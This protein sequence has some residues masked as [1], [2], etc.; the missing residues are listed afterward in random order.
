MNYWDYYNDTYNGMSEDDRLSNG[1]WNG[2]MSCVCVAAAFVLLLVLCALTSC[3]TTKHITVPGMH[4]DTL[5]ISKMQRD[6]IWLHDSIHVTERQQGDTF[7]VEV[8]KWKTKYIE[9]LHTDT[10]IEHHTDSIPYPVEVVKEVPRALTWWQKTRMR[11]GEILIAIFSIAFIIVI[12]KI[13]SKFR[14]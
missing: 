2:C 5:Y 8:A 1:L 10:L 7:F 12:V 3:T 13:T 6:S 11:C 4:T 14:L 9:R